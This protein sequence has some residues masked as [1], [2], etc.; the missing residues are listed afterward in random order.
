MARY[1]AAVKHPGI[2]VAA[3]VLFAALFLL[4]AGLQYNDPDPGIWIAIYVAAAV[5]TLAALHVRG[6]WVAA[7][8]VALV[9]AAWAG[10]LWYSVAGHVEA[11]D[12]WRKM[13]EKGGKVE[14]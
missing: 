3:N 12:F 7:T 11:T 2:L 13:S 4:S 14:E 10:W 6:G 5:A 8:V 1:A 9:C